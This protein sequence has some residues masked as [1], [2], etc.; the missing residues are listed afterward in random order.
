MCTAPSSFPGAQREVASD[1]KDPGCPPGV[2]HSQAV[3][4]GW[5]RGALQL[6]LATLDW[7]ETL[8]IAFNNEGFK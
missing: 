6:A 3:C 4:M 8:V 2:P 7:W 1:L 5:G